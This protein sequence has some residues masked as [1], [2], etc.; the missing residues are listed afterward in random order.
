MKK[1]DKQKVLLVIAEED[2]LE[3]E[4]PD[5]VWAEISSKLAIHPSNS[6][7]REYIQE[8]MR[9]AVIAT[10]SNIINRISKIE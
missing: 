10:K 9:V 6:N 5:D 4:M 7:S 1:I 3:E 8:I 2:E